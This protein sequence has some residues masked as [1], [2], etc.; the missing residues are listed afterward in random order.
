MA[1]EDRLRLLEVG[2]AGHDV[3]EMATG[4]VDQDLLKTFER[5]GRRAP[6][7]TAIGDKDEGINPDLPLVDLLPKLSRDKVIPVV[8]EHQLIG[9]VSPSSVQERIWLQRKLK[10]SD[11]GSNQEKPNLA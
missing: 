3:A 6:A 2:V 4:L 10:N 9:L 11:I 5:L 7:Y 8:E 1:E